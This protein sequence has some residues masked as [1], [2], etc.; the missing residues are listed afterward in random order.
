LSAE[1][2]ENYHNR[3]VKLKREIIESSKA[4]KK[5]TWIIL[6]PVT[7]KSLLYRRRMNLS[8]LDLI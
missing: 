4:L 5:E 2:T 8:L 6:I 3:I 1:E 7:K